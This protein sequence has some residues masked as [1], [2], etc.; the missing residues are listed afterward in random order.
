MRPG[1]KSEGPGHNLSADEDNYWLK[2]EMESHSCITAHN[3]LYNF[4]QFE[5]VVFLTSN[6]ELFLF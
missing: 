5:I 1:K 3:F 6:K 4:A 2:S